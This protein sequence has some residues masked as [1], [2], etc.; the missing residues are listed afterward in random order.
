M[1]F[2]ILGALSVLQ[3]ALSHDICNYR[4]ESQWRW[5]Y[6][7]MTGKSGSPLIEKLPNGRV[8]G[9]RLGSTFIPTSKLKEEIQKECKFLYGKLNV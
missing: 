6:A 2:D 4:S 5:A 7:R 9:L 8:D 1:K 3:F